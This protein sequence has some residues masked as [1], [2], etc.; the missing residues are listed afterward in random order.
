MVV[1][2][3][4]FIVQGSFPL[5]LYRLILC[6]YVMGGGSKVV[7]QIHV[8]KQLDELFERVRHKIIT[9]EDDDGH[10]EKLD[11][12]KSKPEIYRRALEYAVEHLDKWL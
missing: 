7:V 5:L 4:V 6:S 3:L 11:V 1:C 12:S 9:H 8:P 2:K 10:I